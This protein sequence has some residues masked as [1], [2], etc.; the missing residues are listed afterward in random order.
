MTLI[1]TLAIILAVLLTF[2]VAVTCLTN[3]PKG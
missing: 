3:N 1:P 2:S